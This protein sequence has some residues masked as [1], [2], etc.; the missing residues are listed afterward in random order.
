MIHY[1]GTPISSDKVARLVL[2][3]GHALVSFLA[4]QQLHLVTE[5]C[6]SFILDNGLSRL[7]SKENRSPIGN[8]IMSGCLK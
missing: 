5:L 2:E 4:Q 3:G 6:Q 8:L 1:H 7:G